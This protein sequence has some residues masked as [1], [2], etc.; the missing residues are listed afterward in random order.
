MNRYK[1]YIWEILRRLCSIAIVGVIFITP[2]FAWG[3]TARATGELVLARDAII[4]GEAALPGLTILNGSRIKTT[5]QGVVAVNLGRQ[6]RFECGRQTEIVLQLSA[7]IVGGELASGWLRADIPESVKLRITTGTATVSTDGARATNV[8]IESVAG[9][10]IVR[11]K[12][13]AAIIVAN[14][15]TRRVEAN[16]EITIDASRGASSGLLET[17]GVAPQAGR[18]CNLLTF[19]KFGIENSILRNSWKSSAA[20]AYP[21]RTITCRDN[22]SSYCKPRGH[23]RP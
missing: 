16:E 2:N 7:E 19:V 14:G 23:I 9:K 1:K 21:V 12:R 4:N 15:E 17:T 3:Q 8:T 10:M 18:S 11:T 5:E 6:G 13:G 20:R 22:N